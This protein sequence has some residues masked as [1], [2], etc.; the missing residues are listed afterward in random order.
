MRVLRL[1]APSGISPLR[2]AQIA[3]LGERQVEKALQG[4]VEEGLRIGA[5]IMIDTASSPA[6]ESSRERV[7][8][9]VIC[10]GA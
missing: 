7:M 9:A 6:V 5:P 8:I 4:V 10:A 2:G 3:F 1:A